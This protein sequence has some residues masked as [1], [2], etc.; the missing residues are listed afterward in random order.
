MRHI[1]VLGTGLMG[2]GLAHSLLRS[3]L[4]VTVW[5]RTPGRAAPAGIVWVQ[6]ST[7][8]LSDAAGRLPALAAR[9]G[10]RY[11]DAPVLGTRQPAEE[12]RSPST[13]G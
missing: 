2:T 8:S 1:T 4:G 11:I 3:G 10:A 7:V 12:G 5:N 6:T 9:H 13:S